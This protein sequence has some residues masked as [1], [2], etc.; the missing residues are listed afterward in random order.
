MYSCWV[1]ALNFGWK[2]VNVDPDVSMLDSSN[3]SAPRFEPQAV[4]KGVV[5]TLGS[6]CFVASIVLCVRGLRGGF[7][8]Q[9]FLFAPCGRERLFC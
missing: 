9:A 2:L 8:A 5:I 7:A 3:R 6:V 1:V 4:I